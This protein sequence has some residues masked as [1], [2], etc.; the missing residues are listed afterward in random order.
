YA[1]RC[2]EVCGFAF[3]HIADDIALL[4]EIVAAINGQEREVD[5]P[6]AQALDHTVVD[7]SIARVIDTHSPYLEN[8]AQETVAAFPFAFDEAEVVGSGWSFQAMAGGYRKERD[9]TQLEHLARLRSQHALR[10]DAERSRLLH[11][12]ERNDEARV[13]RCLCQ[14]RECLRVEMID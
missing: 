14:A 7:H 11:D 4:P 5:L 9:C 2:R 13:R 10:R 3:V 8:V 6:F 12:R 1:G